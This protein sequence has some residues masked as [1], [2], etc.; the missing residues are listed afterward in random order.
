MANNYYEATGV[1]SLERVTPVISA[2][3][4]AFNLDANYPGNGRAFIARIAETD[5]PQWDDVLEELTDLAAK[6]GISPNS[7][8]GATIDV[9]LEK[10]AR[11]FHADQDEDFENLIE[12]HPFEGD[13]DLEALFFIASRFNDGHN[14]VAIQFEGC[15]YCSRPRLFEFGGH[16]CFISRE[17]NIFRNSTQTRELG[18]DLH[19]ALREGDLTEATTRITLEMASL[20]AGIQ[21]PNSRRILRQR[22]AEGLLHNQD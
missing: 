17:V 9:V 3:F 1:L 2:L 14:L 8:A 21:D 13:A 4:G 11:H 10:L 12:H 20:L 6:L 18:T 19:K 15:W 7:E 16:A 5:D 22:I